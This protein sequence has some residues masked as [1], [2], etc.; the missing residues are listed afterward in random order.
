MEQ[1][2]IR[3]KSREKIVREYDQICPIIKK[4]CYSYL[5]L[6]KL[7]TDV[8]W[9][10][11]FNLMTGSL[12]WMTEKF[13]YILAYQEEPCVEGALKLRLDVGGLRGYYY[14]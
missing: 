11:E 2:K 6:S 1:S 13:Q 12:L 5:N 14:S 3:R 4:K 10:F 7:S 8:Q 9:C